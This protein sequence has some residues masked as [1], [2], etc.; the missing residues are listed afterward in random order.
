MPTK[1]AATVDREARI[2]RGVSLAQAGEALGHNID[3]D[4]KTIA[5]IVE[6]GNNKKA[7]VKARF[8][9]PGLSTDGMGKFL[10]R[11][12]DLRLSEDGTKA[13]GDLHLA[14]SASNSPDGDLAEYVMDLAEEDA[15]AFGMS[16]V[17][18]KTQMA[19]ID[20]AT[21]VE[22]KEKP[23]NSQQKRPYLRFDE[24]SACDV[25]DEPA[26]NRDG[27]FSSSLWG[28]NQTAEAAFIE[29]DAM[30]ARYGVDQAKAW[31]VAQKYFNARGVDLKG[32]TTVEET[33]TITPADAG[34]PGG[35]GNN[36]AAAPNPW[37][38]ALQNS[39]RDAMLMASG[40]PK[41]AQ[42]KL[43]RQ[44][45]ATPDGL[46]D[47]I[48]DERTYLSAFQQ[49]AVKGMAPIITERDMITQRDY[50]QNA[51][52]WMF[53][54]N[55]AMPK[56]SMR[57][58]AGLYVAMTGDSNFWGVFN[59]EEAQFAEATT[60]A[61]AGMA[62]N[63]LNKVIAAHY[64]NMMTYRWFEQVVDVVPHDGSTH[65]I[66]MIY[67]DGLANLPTVSEGGAYTEATPGDSKESMTFSKRGRY[68][69][70]TLEM[71]RK[72]DIVRMR[73]IPK[74]LTL[75]AVRTRSAAV[76]GIFTQ[77]SGVGPTMADDSTALFHANHG[78]LMTTAFSAAAWAS[79]RQKIWEQSVPGTSHPLGMWPKY[80]LVP[81]ELF[82]TAL[83]TFGRG[84]GAD[85]VGRPTSAGTAQEGNIYGETRTGDPRPVPIPVPEWTDANDWAAMTD[86]KL[87]APICMAYAAAQGG[88]S[89]PMPEI[90]TVTSETSG[91]MFTNDTLPVKV[92]DWFAV[93]VS[94]YI[95]I[96]KS[97]V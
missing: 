46:A 44:T 7:G 40:L 72:S 55:V 49:S 21:G 86:P 33:T 22:V 96:G 75:A 88:G 92:R 9:H 24:L 85:M 41:A 68:V 74:A 89:H 13:L 76:G 4:A 37:A 81:I 36:G 97:N 64:D 15:S 42:D 73:A 19:W 30:L 8:T 47:A 54:A 82:D 83:T 78:N 87:H 70:I 77:A 2:I 35:T 14:E 95:G 6:K 56:P 12:K 80:C 93:G 62:V 27:L 67:V 65:D 3:F 63:A 94:T 61:M 34:Q 1:G 91:L 11:I 79:M 45:F 60:T 25:V 18:R 16:V 71:I 23:L 50:Y 26:A 90:F 69:G 29:L 84:A 10:G 43:K 66:Q 51:W 28:S 52:D 39:A 57:N 58:L 17:V 59:P 53:G 48:E 31:E 5:A 32:Q 38:V 20:P